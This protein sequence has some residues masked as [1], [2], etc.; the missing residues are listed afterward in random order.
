M[1]DWRDTAHSWDV[2]ALVVDQHDPDA[3]LGALSG[4]DLSGCTV[5][6]GYYTD[7]RVSA[8]VQTAA[9]AGDGYVDLARIRLILSVP[10]L[11][12]SR[13]LMTGFVTGATPS[14]DRGVTTMR[15][16]LDSTLWALSVDALDHRVVIGSQGSMVEAAGKLI[17]SCGF[18]HDLARAQ[19]RLFQ[20]ATVWEVGDTPLGV[21][22]D[23]CAS[24]SRLGVDGHGLVTMEPYLAPSA[25]S[26]QYDIDPEDP[27]TLVLSEPIEEERGDFEV[28]GKAVAIASVGSGEDVA[29][30]ALATP[31]SRASWERRG[32]RLAKTY[33]WPGSGAPTAAQLSEYAA[34]MLA[35]AADAARRWSLKVA[36]MDAR[37]GDVVS[38]RHR[39]GWHRCLVQSVTTRLGDMTQELTLKEV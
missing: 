2:A 36:Y 16:E 23:M 10:E 37:A 20:T 35:Q 38:Y 9:T 28:P 31:S 19:D 13:E 21:L 15:Y 18:G 11:G 17:D 32:Y 24:S 29:G 25:R 1:T 26:P 12:W 33:S 6:E 30:A 27:R 8:D 14:E 7:T 4:L 34:S 5:T 39:D 3:V 22:Y